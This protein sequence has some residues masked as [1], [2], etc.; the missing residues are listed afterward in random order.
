MA[1]SGAENEFLFQHNFYKKDKSFPL[2]TTFYVYPFLSLN[3]EHW[4]GI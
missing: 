1:D 4:Y 2:T 3:Y